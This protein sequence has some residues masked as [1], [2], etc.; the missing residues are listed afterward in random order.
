[1][2]LQPHHF[3]FCFCICPIYPWIICTPP[4]PRFCSQF[5]TAP[6]T[7]CTTPS[8]TRSRI[9]LHCPPCWCI[10]SL[11]RQL[12]PISTPWLL[13]RLISPLL[14]AAVAASWRWISTWD[15]CSPSPLLLKINPT[16]SGFNVTPLPSP[17]AALYLHIYFKSCI[18][19]RAATADV[20]GKKYF[21]EV[22]TCLG[23]NHQ[24]VLLYFPSIFDK[25]RHPPRP[26]SGENSPKL[27][28]KNSIDITIV[29]I[30][31][32]PQLP[33]PMKTIPLLRSH[34]HQFLQH[35]TNLPICKRK[36]TNKQLSSK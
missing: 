33:L 19:H 36:P 2:L 26:R 17:L 10:F 30:G 12:P 9:S 21:S 3:S 11:Y 20:V 14:S 1:M 34:F 4:P 15:R 6:A 35:L 28:Q 29:K 31:K 27:P 32:Q 16:S 8:R 23:R 24:R 7:K 25:L 18:K 5:L 13:L 22:L